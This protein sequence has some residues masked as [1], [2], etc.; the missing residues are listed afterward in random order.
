MKPRNKSLFLKKNRKSL[1]FF[2]VIT[3]LIVV[4]AII[5]FFRKDKM[6]LT[7][8][9]NIRADLTSTPTSSPTEKKAKN[10]NYTVYSRPFPN[11]TPLF[12]SSTEDADQK[13]VWNFI[14]N[15]F[16]LNSTVN[17]DGS[18]F[19]PFIIKKLQSKYLFNLSGFDI[20]TDSV[21]KNK[22]ITS[23]IENIK[24][25]ITDLGYR[26]IQSN[27]EING[28]IILGS[29]SYGRKDNIFIKNNQIFNLNYFAGDCG[30]NQ[31]GCY[32][33]ISYFNNIKEQVE[34]QL[35][36]INQ[37]DANDQGSSKLIDLL[38]DNRYFESIPNAITYNKY[39][40]FLIGQFNSDTFRFLTEVDANSNLKVIGISPQDDSLLKEL[41]DDVWCAI[42]SLG[43]VGVRNEEETQRCNKYL[44]QY[45]LPDK[46]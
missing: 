42:K 6:N 26:E 23:K 13:N 34:S 37:S 1:L 11:S 16:K 9:S 35:K 24:K 40:I 3:I 32:L 41:P 10:N 43:G 31:N 27:S 21:Q 33:R 38:S 25:Y 2:V 8:Q 39:E 44:K 18:S 36:V 22:N 17:E 12:T 7:F 15:N 45:V 19:T 20:D 14:K 29:S 30:S 28:F 46:N 5:L 4:I